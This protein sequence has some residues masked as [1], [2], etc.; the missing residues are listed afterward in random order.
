MRGQSGAGD[1]SSDIAGRRDH[2]VVGSASAAKFG[3][4]IIAGAHVGSGD[5]AVMRFFKG[6]DKGFVRVAFPDQQTKRF[7]FIAASVGKKKQGDEHHGTKSW[8]VNAAAGIA[9][10]HA[11]TL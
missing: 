1:G 4:E 9:R 10:S 7:R 2:V 11:I 8:D 3:D 6:T 5:F